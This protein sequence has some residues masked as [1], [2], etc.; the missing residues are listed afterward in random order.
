MRLLGAVL[1]LLAA[2]CGNRYRVLEEGPPPPDHFRAAV[3]HLRS[4]QG[5]VESMEE[6]LR[7]TQENYE[8]TEL[9]IRM[10]KRSGAQI[11]ICPE[12]GN[13]GIQVTPSE[14]PYQ[15]TVLP[16]APTAQPLYA[17]TVPGMLPQVSQY[18]R[19]SEELGIYLVTNFIERVER[20]GGTDCYN[21]L[22][23]FDDRGR[24]VARY[25][26]V[27]LYI[28]EHLIEIEGDEVVSFD[29]PWGRFGMLLCLD[30][31]I[32]STWGALKNQHKCDFL[33]TCTLWEE[34]PFTG[35]VAMDLLSVMSGLPVLWSNQRRLPFASGAG[36]YRPWA[37]DTSMGLL[38]DP[39]V[40]VAN[41]PVAERLRKPAGIVA[42]TPR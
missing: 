27:N 12:Y 1:V 2:A 24:L 26:K 21:T 31:I 20:P 22:L 36:V 4:T 9:L 41:L 30:T 42:A 38:S 13:T 34:T 25:R 32:P 15:T 16:A 39:G 40:V 6:G 8:K 37:E 19:L 14:L 7:L 18:S 29:T 33:I 11:V 10:A 23:A 35:H 5:S 3:L 17:M 28:W